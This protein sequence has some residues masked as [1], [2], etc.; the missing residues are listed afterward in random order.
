[1]NTLATWWLHWTLCVCVWCL[2]SMFEHNSSPVVVTH[3]HTHHIIE[4]Y[5][6]LCTIWVLQG[7]TMFKHTHT[8]SI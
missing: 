8:Q 5:P 4:Q 3:T 7:I 6:L 2:I 1:M